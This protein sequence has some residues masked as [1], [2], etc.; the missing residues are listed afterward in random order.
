A[1]R[2]ISRRKLQARQRRSHSHSHFLKRRAD[3]RCRRVRVLTQWTESPN[4]RAPW[5]QR[6]EGAAHPYALPLYLLSKALKFGSF[7]SGSQIGF[8]F[9]ICTVTPL[10]RLNSPSR[11]SIARLFSPTIV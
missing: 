6:R 1:G 4:Q 3:A 11:I 9:R 7:R 2:R 5:L 8:S 10:G